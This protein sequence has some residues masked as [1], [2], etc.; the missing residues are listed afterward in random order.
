M[1]MS[2]GKSNGFS[3]IPYP[4]QLFGLKAYSRLHFAKRGLQLANAYDAITI[5]KNYVGRFITGRK[6][7]LST[8]CPSLLSLESASGFLESMVLGR[9]QRSR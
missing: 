6:L 8:I 1:K 7:Q 9:A 2:N 4:M 3:I 5:K